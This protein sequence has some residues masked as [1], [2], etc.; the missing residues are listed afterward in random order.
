MPRRARSRRDGRFVVCGGPDM[1]PALPQQRLRHACSDRASQHRLRLAWSLRALPSAPGR[2]AS[3]CEGYV[4]V[5]PTRRRPPPDPGSARRPFVLATLGPSLSDHRDLLGRARHRRR[6]RDRVHV[7]LQ[8][9]AGRVLP[10]RADA[11]LPGG[12]HLAPRS[13][14]RGRGDDPRAPGR[15]RGNLSLTG[16][17]RSQW[18]ALRRSRLRAV[19]G[20]RAGPRDAH[21]LP[22]RCAGPAV[23]PSVA[24]ARSV[25]RSL[26]H[27]LPRDRRHGRLHPDVERGHGRAVSASAVRRA[28]GGIELDRR[29]GSIVSTTSTA[30]SLIRRPSGCRRASTSAG[31][32]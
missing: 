28:R 23:V 16:S 15:L 2:P 7:R 21:W 14:G 27:R 12:A 30:S 31:S 13:R 18:A 4:K 22:R 1:A 10:R 9:M 8:P 19:L 20:D 11:A 24:A 26:Q 17:R 6:S 25:R 3:E 32:A 5:R 29:L